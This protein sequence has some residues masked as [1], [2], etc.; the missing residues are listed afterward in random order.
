MR[1][2][3]QYLPTVGTYLVGNYLGRYFDSGGLGMY[4]SMGLV[5]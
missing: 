3:L 1:L 4:R 2:K 5:P